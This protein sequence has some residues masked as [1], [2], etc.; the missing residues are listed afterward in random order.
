[1]IAEPVDLHIGTMIDRLFA[2]CTLLRCP[3]NISRPSQ[4]M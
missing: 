1:V 3:L 4:Q 2:V